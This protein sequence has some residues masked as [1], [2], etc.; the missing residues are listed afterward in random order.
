MDRDVIV[1]RIQSLQYETVRS[2]WAVREID[3]ITS[4][5]YFIIVISTFITALFVDA[6]FAYNFLEGLQQTSSAANQTAATAAANQTGAT[7]AANQTGA[8]D[9]TFL[10]ILIISGSS[11]A[12]VAVGSMLYFRLR[13]LMTNALTA[14]RYR[15]IVDAIKIDKESFDD[16]KKEIEQYLNSGDWVLAEYWTDRLMKEYDDFIRIKWE[17]EEFTK[18][19]IEQTKRE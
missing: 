2:S 11:I 7:A 3:K 6:N 15:V 18:E 5:G 13:D 4:L 9:N 14:F 10:R 17:K 12:G 1:L 16:I 19:K 8:N